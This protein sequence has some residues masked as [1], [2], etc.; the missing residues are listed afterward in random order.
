M[1]VNTFSP[2]N[3]ARVISAVS[4]AELMAIRDARKKTEKDNQRI[5][6]LLFIMLSA[7]KDGGE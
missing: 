1:E 6:V 4:P 2:G 3:K 5:L 7:Y